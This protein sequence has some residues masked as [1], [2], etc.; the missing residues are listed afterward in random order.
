MTRCD[1]ITEPGTDRMLGYGF[2][3][4]KR[5]VDAQKALEEMDGYVVG[6]GAIRV[7]WTR[8]SRPKGFD[9]KIINVLDPSV[10]RRVLKELFAQFGDIR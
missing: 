3:G 1:L 7:A 9:V 2:V 8:R 5:F 4:Y 6:Q 10:D